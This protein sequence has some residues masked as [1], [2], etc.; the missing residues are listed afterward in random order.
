MFE[1]AH[2]GKPSIHSEAS[3]PVKWARGAYVERDVVSTKAFAHVDVV[4]MVIY[5]GTEPTKVLRVILCEHVDGGVAMG[6]YVCV[7]ARM[8]VCVCVGGGCMWTWPC[9]RGMCAY[10]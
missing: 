6:M 8:C 5:V 10:V 7:C 2:L 4:S 1:Q 3:N 9:G